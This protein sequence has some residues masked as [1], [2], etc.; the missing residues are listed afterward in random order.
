MAIASHSY[1]KFK[2]GFASCRPLPGNTNRS[3]QLYI[4]I[5]NHNYFH[6]TY[7]YNNSTCISVYS[8]MY[9]YM[10]IVIT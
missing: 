9:V 10:Y 6:S 4:I 3:M 7:G 1:C 2:F 8:D 5:C